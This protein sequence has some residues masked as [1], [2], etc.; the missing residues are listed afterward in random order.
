MTKTRLSMAMLCRE[1]ERERERERCWMSVYGH[2]SLHSF[3]RTGGLLEG[4]LMG[5]ANK[6]IQIKNRNNK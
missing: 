6:Y 1:G 5:G 4:G 3:D 2:S